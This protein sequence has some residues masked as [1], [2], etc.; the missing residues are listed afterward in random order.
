VAAVVGLEGWASGE[1]VD[2]RHHPVRGR[3]NNMSCA[4]GRELGTPSRSV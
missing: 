1:S 2:T 4:E 3:A